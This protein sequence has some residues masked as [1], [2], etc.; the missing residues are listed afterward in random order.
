M[1]QDLND[2]YYFVQTVDHGGF[3]PAGRALSIPKSRLSRRIAELENRL[4]VRLIQ[5]SSR[6]FNPTEI[7]RIYYRHCKAMLVEA[8]AAQ[9]AINA[10]RAEPCGTIKLSCPTTLLHL[11]VGDVLA[12][13]MAQYPKVSVQV[14]ATNR[15]VDVLAEHFDMAIR[16][17]P[18]P[19]DDSELQLRVLSDRGQCLVASP[20][21]FDR[22][23]P[24]QS[25]NDLTDWPSMARAS[26]NERQYWV[27][28]GANQQPMQIAHQPRL[29]TTDMITLRTAALAGIGIVQ[30][31]RIMVHEQ[32]KAGSLVPVLP[33]WPLRREVIHLVFPS[34]RGLLPAVRL[35]IDQLAAAYAALDEC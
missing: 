35:L 21:L 7:G 25:P 19:L 3:A 6:R 22:M 32:L 30:L 24:P 31:P 33:D 15:Q 1:K 13:F 2:L 8:D 29:M 28:Q 18:L 23:L 20:G 10:V 16:A 4:G 12:K 11:H 14:A 34:R 17:R 27:F 9:Q 26:A 5:R